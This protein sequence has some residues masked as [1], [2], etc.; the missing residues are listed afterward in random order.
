MI[1]QFD[2]EG[3]L[4][5]GV[6]DATW[7]E[8]AARYGTNT[9]RQQLL[10]GL[11]QGL[12]AL[13][14]AGCHT[15]YVDGSFVTDKIEPNDFDATWDVQ[16]VD[17]S[18]IDPV[19]LDFEDMRRKQKLKFRGE[20]FP[21]NAAANPAGQVFLDFFQTRKDNGQPKGIVRINLDK[22]S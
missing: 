14:H 16:D 9:R 22:L 6:H 13:K 20:F 5:Q 1:P 15:A 19:L 7:E 18:L 4:P 8:L 3:Y 21:S 17:G 10:A 12:R 2:N 11:L